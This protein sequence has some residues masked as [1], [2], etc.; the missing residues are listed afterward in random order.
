MFSERVNNFF[1]VNK[2]IHCVVKGSGQTS[3]DKQLTLYQTTN[4]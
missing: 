2:S 1:E 3:N 4:F